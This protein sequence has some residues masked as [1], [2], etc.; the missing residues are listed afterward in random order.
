M[1]QSK[2][3]LKRHVIL[4]ANKKAEEL[5]GIER[6]PEF[7]ELLTEALDVAVVEQGGDDSGI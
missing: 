4:E 7:E 1:G 2:A 5:E 3:E 6:Q